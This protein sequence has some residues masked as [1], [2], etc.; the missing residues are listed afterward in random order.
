MANAGYNLATLSPADRLTVSADRLACLIR[1]EIRSLTGTE[2][3]RMA[4]LL[5][6]KYSAELQPLIEKAMKVRA[7]GNSRSGGGK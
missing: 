4:V 1:W 2:R 6:G 3:Q 5:L 7:K